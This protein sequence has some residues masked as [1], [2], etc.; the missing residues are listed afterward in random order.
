M[1]LVRTNAILPFA[2][3]ADADLTGLEGYF[4][5]ADAASGRVALVTAANNNPFGVILNGVEAPEKNSIALTVGLAGTVRVKLGGNVSFGA[6]LKLRADAR[7]DAATGA[8]GEMLVGF[9]LESGTADD[10]VEA[11]LATPILL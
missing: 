2:A 5:K 1:Q 8:A 7:V 9:A 10:L 3:L 4:V 11:A 6:T